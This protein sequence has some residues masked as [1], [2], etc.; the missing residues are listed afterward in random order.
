MKLK[1]QYTIDESALPK[2]LQNLFERRRDRFDNALSY[3]S[4]GLLNS[5]DSQDY[6]TAREQVSTLRKQLYDFDLVLDDIDNILQGYI[7]YKHPRPSDETIAD[8]LAEED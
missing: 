5:I 6:G 2:E 4:E 1:I 3:S 8:V 7:E